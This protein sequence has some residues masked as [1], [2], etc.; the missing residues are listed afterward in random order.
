MLL[1]L[2]KLTL[3]LTPDSLALRLVDALASRTQRPPLDQVQRDAIHQAQSLRYGTQASHTA[4]SWGEWPSGAN[5]APGQAYS[6]A[7]LS[8]S[9]PR[10]YRSRRLPRRTHAMAILPQRPAAVAQGTG[11]RHPYPDRPLSWCPG[12]DG[13]PPCRRSRS[14]PLCLYLCALSP[15]SAHRGDP[16]QAGSSTGSHPT[17]PGTDSRAVGRI[18]GRYAG[19]CVL[20]RTQREDPA[21]LRPG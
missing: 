14:Q 10:H 9:G 11:A 2:A 13:C 3:N 8:R 4:W 20:P 17:L 18:L 1:D 7:R 21:D 12:H 19:R 6:R 15:F 16:P 5:G